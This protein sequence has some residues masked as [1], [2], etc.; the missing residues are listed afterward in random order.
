MFRFAR[1][2]RW[3]VVSLVLAIAAMASSAAPDL[4]SDSSRMYLHKGWQ[5]QSSCEMKAKAE[6]VATVGFDAS[7]WHQTNVPTTVVAA[8]VA[9][10]TYPDPFYAKNLKSFPGMYQ[11]NKELWAN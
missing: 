11:S 2:V 1:Y 3:V 10:K 9:D 7:K 4:A 8:L 5:L 6:Q